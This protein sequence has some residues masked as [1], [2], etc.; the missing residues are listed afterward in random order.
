[1]IDE[2]TQFQIYYPPFESAIE[3]EVGSFMCSYNLI[4]TVWACENNQTL[5][6]DLRERMGFKGYVMSD[7]G[8]THSL[9][10][11]K[12]MDQEMN[13][14]FHNRFYNAHKLKE[15]PEEVDQSNIRMFTQFF[16]IG[17]FDQVPDSNR[18]M[19]ANVTTGE[20]KEKAK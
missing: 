15:F 13:F 11:D 3:A 12:G 14:D 4:N 20:R 10:V 8:A 1:M 6:T 5:N 16:K 17:S 7:W 2:R 9:A 19:S 18:N